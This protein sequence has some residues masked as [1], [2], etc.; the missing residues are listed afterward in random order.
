MSSLLTFPALEFYALQNK[1]I[2]RLI[3]MWNFPKGVN[4][5][6]VGVHEAIVICIFVVDV[7]QYYSFGS[8]QFIIVIYILWFDHFTIL[9]ILILHKRNEAWRN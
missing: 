8:L 4:D 3:S 2:I 5:V 1:N 9:F 6:A 7:T